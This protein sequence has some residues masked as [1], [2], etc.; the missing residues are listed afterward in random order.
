MTITSG[1]RTTRFNRSVGGSWN[2]FHLK[3]LAADWKTDFTGWTRIALMKLFKSAGF[4]NV[5]FYY[6]KD[7]YGKWQISRVHTDIGK[8]WNGESFYVAKNKYE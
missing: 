8:T 3:G 4:T 5:G 2:S 7:K 1:T 6:K